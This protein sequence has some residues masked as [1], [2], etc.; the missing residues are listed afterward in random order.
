MNHCLVCLFQATVEA[1]KITGKQKG[2][3]CVCELSSSL[4]AFPTVKFEKVA[5]QVQTCEDNLTEFHK[6][7]RSCHRF[8]LEV[9]NVSELICVVTFR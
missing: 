8:V 2:D 5:K 6:K 4:W 3:S 7:V 1:Q 9:H